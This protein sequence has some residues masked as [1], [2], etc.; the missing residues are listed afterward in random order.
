MRE[1]EDI[2][3]YD[4]M[5][6]TEAILSCLV[7]E[8]EREDPETAFA[9]VM[10]DFSGIQKYIFQI[11]TTNSSGVAKRL[12]ARSFYVDIMVRSFAQYVAERFGVGRANVLLETGG[13]FY[14]LIPWRQGAE[15]KLRK[16][17]ASLEQFLFNRFEGTV[18]VNIAWLPVGEEGIC[19]YSESI[20]ELNRRLSEEKARPF[21]SVLKHEGQWNE[22]AFLVTNELKNKKMCP[23]CNAS[24]IDKDQECCRSCG[25]Q[26]EIGRKIPR[27]QFIVYRHEKK[28]GTYHVFEDIYIELTDK[29]NFEG[30]FLV[31]ALRQPGQGPHFYKYPVIQQYMVNH[32]PQDSEGNIL[33]FSEIADQSKGVKKLAV[34]KMDVDVLGYLFADGLRGKKRHFGTISRVN[35]MSRMLAL[36]FGGYINT[37]LENRKNGYWNTY[38]VFSG[39]DDLF[40]I[41]QWDRMPDLA[42]LIHDEFNRFTGMNPAMSVS[43]T[44]S[45]FNKK[46]HVAY[47]AEQSEEQLKKAKNESSEKLYP[48][49][50]GRNSICFSNDVYSWEDFQRQLHIA[51]MFE[52][53]IIKKRLTSGILRRLAEYSLMYRDYILNGRPEGLMAVPL[54]NYDYSRNYR[55]GDKDEVEKAIKEYVCAMKDYDEKEIKTKIDIYFAANTVM[56]AMNLT[57]EG[58]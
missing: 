39:G 37:L 26:L 58:R 10:A 35:T 40:L 42:L 52:Q 43:A 19:K 38:S 30:A 46:S 25:E 13:K 31:G 56:H 57:R 51:K 41:G 45:V 55:L 29:T 7:M 20:T 36:F 34:L 33:T 48:G 16:I 22:S 9:L 5:K 4:Y 32:I 2:S 49:K 17:R 24:L 18:S 8:G 28:P 23:S 14:L 50:G 44:V 54:L 53:L 27:S 11:A 12:R 3:L 1:D 47:M 21:T 15:E 6:L